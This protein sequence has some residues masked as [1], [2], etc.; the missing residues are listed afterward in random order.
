MNII[1]FSLTILVIYGIMT[2]AYSAIK[3]ADIKEKMEEIEDIE[4]QCE[5]IK[6]F[7]KTHKGDLK[8]Q[9]ET[10]TTFTKE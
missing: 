6:E 4:K 3:N 2:Y 1:I 9:K 10:I 5:T 8:K 7:K